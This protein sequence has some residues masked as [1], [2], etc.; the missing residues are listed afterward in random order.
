MSE[1]SDERT[2][3]EAADRLW[4]AALSGKP[5][6]PVRDLI[7]ADAAADAY[8]VQQ[9]NVERLVTERGWRVCGRKIGLT[10]P[11]VQAQL[12]VDQPDFGTLFAELGKHEIF[13]PT[14]SYP[15]LTLKDLA[16]A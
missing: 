5:C 1:R 8:R 15:A 4:E 3:V 9:H 11:A 16:S 12:G 14:K 2:L 13:T 6:E 7:A 10:S